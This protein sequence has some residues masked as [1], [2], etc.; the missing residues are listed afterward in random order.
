M[1]FSTLFEFGKTTA[2]VFLL[3]DY[4]IRNYPCQRN[5]F[6]LDVAFNIIYAY[7]YCQMYINNGLSYIAIKT[8]FLIDTFKKNTEKLSNIEFVKDNSV[9]SVKGNLNDHT[10][11]VPNY[12]F[13]I[14]TDNKTIPSNIKIIH[15]DI[16]FSNEEIYQCEISEIKFILVE[17]IINEKVYIIELSNKKYNFYVENNIFDKNFFIYFLRYLHPDKIFIENDE[18]D[19]ITLKIIDHD[20]NVKTIEF[21]KENQYIKLH[22]SSYEI[23]TQ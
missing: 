6:L 5:K 22:K 21:T 2:I 23:I 4:F 8:P 19:E 15:N 10:F 20:I 18:N 11:K 17:F 14:Y 1:F 12:D 9:V 7:S 3:N 16:E 13:I